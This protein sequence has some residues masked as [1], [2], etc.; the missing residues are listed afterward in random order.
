MEQGGTVRSK[1]LL[2]YGYL[3][4]R[5]MLLLYGKGCYRTVKGTAV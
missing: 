5:K 4:Y 2:L 1:V 3:L